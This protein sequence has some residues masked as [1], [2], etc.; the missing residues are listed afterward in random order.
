M[1]I[2]L[3]WIIPILP[4][5]NTPKW[6]NTCANPSAKTMVRKGFLG[7]GATLFSDKMSSLDYPL[8]NIQKTIENGHRNC[9]FFRQ[10]W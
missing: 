10:K 2:L 4:T 8:V 3:Q 1:A 7:I 6:P 5:S 9:E